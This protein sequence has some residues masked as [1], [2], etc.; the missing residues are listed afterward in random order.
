MFTSKSASAV[1]KRLVSSFAKKRDVKA[2]FPTTFHPTRSANKTRIL[3][4]EGVV[5]NPPAAVP[6]PH[7][8][9][10]AFL[11]NSDPRKTAPWNSKQH[12]ISNMPQLSDNKKQYNLTEAEVK[13]IQ[14]LRIEDPE[15]WTRKALAAKFNCSPFFI[16]IASNTTVERQQQM[17]ETLEIIKSRWTEHRKKIRADRVRRREVWARDA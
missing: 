13:E 3:L 8:T 12:D 11:P 2:P 1:Q 10:A 9:P 14:R 15:K 17:N 6:T 5:Y 16:S 4:P 7:Q